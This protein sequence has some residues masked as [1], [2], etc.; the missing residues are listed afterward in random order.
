MVSGEGENSVVSKEHD[1]SLPCKIVFLMKP[2]FSFKDFFKSRVFSSLLPQGLIFYK[3]KKS[4]LEN[5]VSWRS[6]LILPHWGLKG[7]ARISGFTLKVC[8][9]WNVY[10]SPLNKVTPQIGHRE[11]SEP[12]HS[13]PKKWSPSSFWEKDHTLCFTNVIF[14][15]SLLG[16]YILV[17]QIWKLNFNFDSFKIGKNVRGKWW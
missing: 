13:L 17:N 2:F 6:Q 3:R 9:L 1:W 5:I 8:V 11:Y 15:P 10:F 16:T 12:S 7:F 14:N 4:S